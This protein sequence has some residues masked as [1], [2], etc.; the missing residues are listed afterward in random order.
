[1]SLLD[2]LSVPA[3]VFLFAASSLVG[4]EVGFRLGRW[5]Q[6]RM[7]GEQEGPTGVLVG[8][9]LGLMA[10]LLA[11]TMGMASDRFDNRRGLV[12]EEATAIGAAYL[13]ADYLPQP[14]RDGLKEVLREYL[15]LRIATGESPRSKRT[16]R[17]P[18]SCS[19]TCGRSFAAAAESA[20]ALT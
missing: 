19:R 15:P 18:W 5:W 20:T 2:S 13:Q 1:M 4:Y 3:I 11:V 16:R 10:F 7:P 6:D 14:S 12:V 17:D 8:G 9:L